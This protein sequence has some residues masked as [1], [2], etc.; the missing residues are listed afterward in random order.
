[1]KIIQEINE[2]LPTHW[3]FFGPKWFCWTLVFIGAL[4]WIVEPTFKSLGLYDYG[5]LYNLVN[6]TAEAFDSENYLLFSVLL[7]FISMVMMSLIFYFPSFWVLATNVVSK[8][9]T[10]GYFYLAIL[11]FPLW[12]NYLFYR[13]VELIIN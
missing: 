1:M 13:I 5:P 7:I 9:F 3:S 6:I 4:G 11:F 12:F 10:N 2:K 8:N